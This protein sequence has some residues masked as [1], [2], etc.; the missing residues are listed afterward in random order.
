MNKREEIIARA[1]AETEKFKQENPDKE[2]KNCIVV[3]GTT[4]LSEE[5]LAQKVI[6]AKKDGL[7]IL[8]ITPEEMHEVEQEMT[9]EIKPKSILKFVAPIV[10][11]EE[12]KILTSLRRDSDYRKQQLKLQQKNFN[13]NASR[14]FKRR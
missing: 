2:F 12:T 8:V 6:D 7:V 10:C 11:M 3:V 9:F 1:S 4:G 14:N 13:R 5:K